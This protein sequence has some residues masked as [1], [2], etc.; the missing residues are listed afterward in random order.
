MCVT[1]LAHLTTSYDHIIYMMKS[2]NYEIIQFSLASCY[3]FHFRIKHS[4]L[5]PLKTEFLNKFI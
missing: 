3:F 5:N 4:S 2:P 1:F